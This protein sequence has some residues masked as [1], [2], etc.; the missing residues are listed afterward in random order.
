VPAEPDPV[1]ADA[2]DAGDPVL[3]LAEQ[4]PA[5]RT[6]TIAPQAV[7]IAPQIMLETGSF[8]PRPPVDA[9]SFSVFVTIGD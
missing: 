1:P 8:T 9:L 7:Q 4:R 2:E 3:Q 6:G 5:R